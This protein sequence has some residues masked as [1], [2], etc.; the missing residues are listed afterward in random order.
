MCGGVYSHGGSGN[1][2]YMSSD[3]NSFTIYYGIRP[4]ITIKADLEDIFNITFNANGGNEIDINKEIKYG[5]KYGD[6]P[7]PIH[8]NSSYTFSGWYTENGEKIESTTIMKKYKDHTLTA[9]WKT[10]SGYEIMNDVNKDGIVDIGDEITVGTES[11]YVISHSETELNALAKYNL[12]VGGIYSYYYY[13]KKHILESTI[14]TTEDG[15]GIQNAGM[16]SLDYYDKKYGTVP[17]SNATGW[18][19]ETIRN[20]AY[21]VGAGV[22]A[23][24]MTALDALYTSNEE[25]GIK[26]YEKY[27]QETKPDIN[28]SVRLITKG[29]IE[30]LI[31]DGNALSSGQ[32]NNK[33]F[34]KGYTWLYSTSYWIQATLGNDAWYVDSQGEMRYSNFDIYNMFGVRPVITI[35][36]S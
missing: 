2:A 9:R 23:D 10:N 35:S 31:N 20:E 5:N 15:Y 28:V 16:I 7:T 14:Q 33:A 19:D 8:N 12:K 25:T 26:G 11:F 24:T 30:G 21:R 3:T 6:L 32:I 22:T 17:F 18:T 36:V 34:D 29:E 13:R 1:L 4:V 27:I